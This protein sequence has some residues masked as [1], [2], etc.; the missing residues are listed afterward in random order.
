MGKSAAVVARLRRSKPNRPGLGRKRRGKGFSYVDESGAR[1]TDDDVKARIVSLVI[2][3]AWEDVWISPDPLGHIQATGID[4]A[5]R[6]QYVYHPDWRAR[7]D[8]VKH[9]HVL[10]IGERLPGARERIAEDLESRGLN[11]RRVLAAA[12]RMLD[13]G[14]FRVGGERYAEQNASYG[15]ATI[16]RKHV[17]VERGGIVTFDYPAKSGRQRVQSLAEPKLVAVIRALVSRRGGGHELLAYTEGRRW[18]DV[19]SE[20]INDYLREVV[21][22][23]VSAKDFRTWHGTVLA[24]IALAVVESEGMSPTARKRVVSH[25]VRE[26]AEYLGNTPAVCRGSYI[27]PRVIDRFESGETIGAVIPRLGAGTE[28]GQLASIGA[29]ERAVLRLLS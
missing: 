27:D 2:P 28:D 4:A 29:A 14:F 6:R 7:R 5:G 8:A 13:L 1:L 11:R 19:R 22:V 21:G 10:E 15:L 17:S 23:E 3:P 9:D 12:A 16:R 26:V 18:Y 24:A 25:A 20:D